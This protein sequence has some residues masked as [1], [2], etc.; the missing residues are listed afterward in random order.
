MVSFFKRIGWDKYRF[1]GLYLENKYIRMNV[2]IVWLRRNVKKIN[3]KEK[4]V[5]LG[6]VKCVRILIIKI[7]KK[8]Y[9]KYRVIIIGV[10][11]VVVGYFIKLSFL[12]E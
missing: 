7:Y 9:E 3:V 12:V 5:I 1:I 11:I 10:Y 2:N 4:N 8:E 6:F